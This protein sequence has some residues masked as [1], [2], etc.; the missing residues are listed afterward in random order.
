MQITRKG[1][2]ALGRVESIRAFEVWGFEL[3]TSKYQATMTVVIWERYSYAMKE[4]DLSLK[5][6]HKQQGNVGI[7]HM[8]LTM[9]VWREEKRIGLIL[10]RASNKSLNHP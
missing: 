3:G 1:I 4:R 7:Q 6:F 2:G 8:R 5:E 10:S 9:V